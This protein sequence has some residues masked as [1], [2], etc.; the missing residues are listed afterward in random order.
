MRLQ[1]LELGVVAGKPGESGW[2]GVREIS[3]E[4]FAGMRRAKRELAGAV[5]GVDLEWV[6]Q[7]FEVRGLRRVGVRALVEHC[8]GAVSEMMA[9]WIAFSKSVEGGFREWVKS[10]MVSAV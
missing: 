7:L 2:D 1:R 5:G 8:P 9:F 6:E 3:A 10:V 4:V